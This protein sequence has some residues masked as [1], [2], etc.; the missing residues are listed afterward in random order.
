MEKYI[1]DK[2]KGFSINNEYTQ[3]QL[4]VDIACSLCDEYGW[5][6]NEV[7]YF[8]TYFDR[9]EF[10]EI[11]KLEFNYNK[12]YTYILKAARKCHNVYAIA[13]LLFYKTYKNVIEETEYYV[14]NVSLLQEM[15]QILENIEEKDGFAHFILA[16]AYFNGRGVDASIEKIT[17]HFSIALKDGIEIAEL[18]I[19]QLNQDDKRMFECASNLILK[20]PRNH[21]VKFF[22]GYCYFYG[23]GTKENNK[24][25]VECFKHTIKIKSYNDDPV[26]IYFLRSRY[27][28]GLC[29]FHGYGVNKNLDNAH[30]LFRFSVSE[31]VKESAYCQAIT[32]L[33]TTKEKINTKYV[34]ELL[35]KSAILKY[36]P[37]IRKLKLCYKVGYGTQIDNEK[38]QKYNEYYNEKNNGENCVSSL[39]KAN[40]LC[41]LIN[42]DGTTIKDD[43][44]LL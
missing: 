16:S 40:D 36:L 19:C 8:H 9:I 27:Y 12:A 35:E 18:Y 32:Y 20:Y 1:I 6:S 15:V 43:E 14:T 29:Y 28:L 21:I 42:Y 41:D 34:F 5:N 10:C 23:I 13:T 2:I 25:A 39:K 24:K 3:E 44:P 38:Y 26:D 7:K 30:T 4:I 17:K 33:L 31:Y 37:A 11:T 22:L